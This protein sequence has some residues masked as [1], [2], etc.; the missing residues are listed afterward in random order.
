MM[1]STFGVRVNNVCY[2]ELAE[3]MRFWAGKRL[4]PCLITCQHLCVGKVKYI[5]L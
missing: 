2:V 4:Y 3:L 1:Y 5:D